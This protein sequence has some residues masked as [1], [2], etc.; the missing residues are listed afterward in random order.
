[1]R[2]LYRAMMVLDQAERAGV[3]DR[4][5]RAKS[6]FS[7]SHLYTG[8]RYT[9]I[10]E[11]LGLRDVD[12]ANPVPKGKVRELG[13]LCTWLYGSKSRA[14]D[15]VIRSQNPDLRIL[16]EVLQH[17][18]GVAALR[19][20]LPLGVS[21]DVT[22]GDE[23]ILRE[24]LVQAKQAL[25]EARGVVATGYSGQPDL[26]KTAEDASETADAIYDEMLEKRSSLRRRRA[27]RRQ[28]A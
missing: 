11:F 20:G 9:G 6:H 4:G 17:R 5:D 8:L 19:R 25:Q 16:D 21:L 13:E 22:K 3:F 1:V 2:R 14:R 7:F 23:E 10:Q 26:L 27:R 24:A 12:S 18:D 15:P 28:P